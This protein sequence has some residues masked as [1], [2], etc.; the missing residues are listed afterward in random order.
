MD[1]DAGAGP[2]NFTVIPARLFVEPSPVVTVTLPLMDAV[3]VC[4]SA[5]VCWA[6]PGIAKIARARSNRPRRKLDENLAVLPQYFTG[7]LLDQIAV[8][9]L[10]LWREGRG[11][12]WCSVGRTSPRQMGWSAKTR[13]LSEFGRMDHNKEVN[14][15]ELRANL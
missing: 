4:E 10:E 2:V 1:D 7:A 15:N 8:L 6:N 9:F 13:S 14:L 3:K 11:Q 12:L 5:P